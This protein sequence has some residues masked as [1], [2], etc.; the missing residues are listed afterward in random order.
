MNN[1]FP[2]LYPQEAYSEQNNAGAFTNNKNS[3]YY[4]APLSQTQNQQQ[5]PLSSIL[6]NLTNNSSGSLN[7]AILPLLLKS[8][9]GG[10]ANSL[11]ED[12][13]NDNPLLNLFSGMG[14][15]KKSPP[16]NVGEKAF[17]D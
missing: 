14:Q 11:A 8:I 10:M 15:N 16:K 7:N 5:N 13:P 3:A 17:P 4:D 9:S 12:K 2:P 1:N 6:S